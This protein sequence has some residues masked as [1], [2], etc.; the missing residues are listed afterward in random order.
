[1]LYRI[2][3]SS[4]LYCLHEPR[5]ARCWASWERNHLWTERKTNAQPQQVYFYTGFK[6]MEK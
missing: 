4:T 1:M 5:A 6:K 2:S 3:Y